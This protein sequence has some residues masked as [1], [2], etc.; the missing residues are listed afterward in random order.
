MLRIWTNHRL[1]ETECAELDA[2]R[3]G[4]GAHELQIFPESDNGAAGPAFEALKTADIVFG[5]PDADAVLAC[6]NVKWL[7]VRLAGYTP[8]DRE[9]FRQLFAEQRRIMTN[10]SSVYVEPCAQHVLAMMMALARRL[11]ESRDAQRGE[12]GWDY[13]GTRERSYVLNGQSALIVGF[14]TIGRRLA[15][16][17][18]PLKMNLTGAKRTIRGDEPI[19]MCHL[20]KIDEALPKFDHVINILPENPSTNLFFDAARFAKLKPGA[21]FYNIGRGTTVDQNA[22]LE[23]L[24]NGRIAAAFLDVTEPEPLPPS[25]PL[26]SAPNC[27]ITPHS[28]GGFAAENARHVEHFLANLRL[29]ENGEAMLDRIY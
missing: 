26:W 11:P 27:F 18:V 13:F 3:E 10:S 12:R 4:V 1:A 7:Q 15:E 14:G 24:N 23:G 16:L 17:L 8:Y 29:F 22:L 21:K 19:A 6:S 20:E 2:L 5:T 28:A 9:D 25:H